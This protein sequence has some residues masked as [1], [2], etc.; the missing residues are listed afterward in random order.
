MAAGWKRILTTEDGTLATSDQTIEAGESRNVTT[1]NSTLFT[2]KTSNVDSGL[3]GGALIQLFDSAGGGTTDILTLQ[4]NQT[5]L[6]VTG[7][8]DSVS[9]SLSFKEADDNGSSMVTLAA[10]TSLAGSTT[11][12]LPATYPSSNGQVLSSTTAGVM[13]WASASG[14]NLGSANLQSDDTARTFT[15]KDETGSSFEIKTQNSGG[16]NFKLT[17]GGV[18]RMTGL[19][20]GVTVLSS[21]TLLETAVPS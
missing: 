17:S 2:I 20:S 4:A 19:Q 1:A 16:A 21:E 3:D 18:A 10:P 8:S 6:R 13:S 9:G 14:D 12:T 7:A 11:Y 5:K 15:T